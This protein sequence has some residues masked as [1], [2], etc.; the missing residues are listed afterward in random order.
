MKPAHCPMC[1]SAVDAA[2][3]IAANTYEM[4]CERCG[5]PCV[6][7]N[8]RRRRPDVPD[9]LAILKDALSYLDRGGIA[10]DEWYRLSPEHIGAFRR[11]IAKAEGR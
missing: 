6:V 7:E 2:R 4:L 1:G 10:T 9:L 8:T 5:I 3:H 11:V